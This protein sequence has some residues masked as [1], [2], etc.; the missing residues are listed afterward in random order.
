MLSGILALRQQIHQHLLQNVRSTMRC[1]HK[2]QLHFGRHLLRCGAVFRM[3][4]AM[5][6][7]Q[8]HCPSA[9][10]AVGLDE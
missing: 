1:N 8:D 5:R 10:Y 3:R 4:A 7:S 2:A 6:A 9:N